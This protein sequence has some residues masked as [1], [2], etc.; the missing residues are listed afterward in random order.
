MN[1]HSITLFLGM[2]ECWGISLWLKEKF[3]NIILFKISYP[4]FYFAPLQNIY[5]H[6]Y[7]SQQKS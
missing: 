3:Y 2:F 1:I 7:I 4:L 5:L 6:F